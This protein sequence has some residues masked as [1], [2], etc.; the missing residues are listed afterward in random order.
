MIFSFIKQRN[1]RR[2]AQL[3]EDLSSK[4]EFTK[5]EENQKKLDYKLLAIP[6]VCDQIENSTKNITLTL[7]AA[8]IT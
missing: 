2:K 8:S 1:D 6:A 5:S 3:I 4:E 7:I